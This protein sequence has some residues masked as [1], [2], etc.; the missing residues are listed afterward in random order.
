MELVNKKSMAIKNGTGRAA[1]R[2][3]VAVREKGLYFTVAIAR[4][5]PLRIGEYVHF[6]NEG[7]R[8][9]FFVNDDKDGFPLTPVIKKGGFNITS[10]A[11]AKLIQKTTGYTTTKNYEVRKTG[12]EQDKCPIFELITTSQ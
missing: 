8:W 2:H 4:E 3:Y 1:Q 10:S 12:G 11:L 5:V 7:N 9:Q 6:M